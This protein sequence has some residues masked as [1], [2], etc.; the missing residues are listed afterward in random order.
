MN[1]HAALKNQYHAA[2]AMLRQAVEHYPADLWLDATH[3]LPA[4]HVAYH[5]LFYTHLYLSANEQ[6]FQPWRHHR[7]EYQ[8]LTRL[9]F[10]PHRPPNI[11]DPYTQPQILDYWQCCDETVDTAIDQLDLA[12]PD[13]GFPWYPVPKLEHQI[14]NIRHL[15][16]HT[17]ILSS[18]LRQATNT[19]LPWVGRA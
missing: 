18:R 15:Q 7:P 3:T 13:S 19:D 17:A 10:P 8:F 2:L 1:V 16:H 14:I 9:P 4:W 6:A 12:A 11:N 5:T